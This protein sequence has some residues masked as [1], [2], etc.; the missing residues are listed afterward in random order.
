MNVVK[1]IVNKG[2]ITSITNTKLDIDNS[3]LGALHEDQPKDSR[4]T[5]NLQILKELGFHRHL[6]QNL[7]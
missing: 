6:I 3:S 1:V 7:I 5:L 2:G 4:C